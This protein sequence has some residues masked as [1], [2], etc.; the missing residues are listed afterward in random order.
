MANLLAHDAGGVELR[1]IIADNLLSYNL[2]GNEELENALKEM[3]KAVKEDERALYKRLAVGD[4]KGF[5][6]KLEQIKTGELDFLL[7]TGEIV[8]HYVSNYTFP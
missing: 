5:I 4:Y 6:H 1:R 8:K 2:K 7:S 3:L